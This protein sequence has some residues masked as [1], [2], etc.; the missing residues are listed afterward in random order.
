MLIFL[1]EHLMCSDPL[2]SP[3]S[4]LH[5]L[6]TELLPFRFPSYR[7]DDFQREDLVSIADTC[8]IQVICLCHRFGDLHVCFPW[9]LKWWVLSRVKASGSSKIVCGIKSKPACHS[10]TKMLSPRPVL[11]W[12]KAAYF[13]DWKVQD[14]QEGGSQGR[15]CHDFGGLKWIPTK[16]NFGLK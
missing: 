15:N 5:L 6:S 3:L 14:M 16:N 1:W 7:D 11:G 12:F 13:V 10:H 2:P 9:C 8:I 4:S